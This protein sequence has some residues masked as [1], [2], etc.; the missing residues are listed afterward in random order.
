VLYCSGT[1]IATTCCYSA[2][3]IVGCR[4]AKWKKL[5]MILGIVHRHPS[6]I[7]STAIRV[8]E[9]QL[10]LDGTAFHSAHPPAGFPVSPF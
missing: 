1:V 9:H 6:A 8:D 4:V 5:I 10:L 7:L 2:R 3:L